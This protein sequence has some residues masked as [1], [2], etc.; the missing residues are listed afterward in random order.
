MAE[1]KESK[2]KDFS[3]LPFSKVGSKTKITAK[4]VIIK[5][6]KAKNT[7]KIRKIALEHDHDNPEVVLHENNGKIEVIE[8]ICTCGKRTKVQVN[9]S[10]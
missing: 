1:D 10:E 7:G 3:E 2:F 9:Y 5:Q 4:D 8:F 6:N